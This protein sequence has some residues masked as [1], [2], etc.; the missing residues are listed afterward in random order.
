MP[1]WL[2]KIQT[3]SRS[4]LELSPKTAIWPWF[5]RQQK[6]GKVARD[7]EGGRA[8]WKR[9]CRLADAGSRKGIS[10]KE[11]TKR[12]V[13]TALFPRSPFTRENPSAVPI[14]V[15]AL[16]SVFCVPFPVFL[17]P[18]PPPHPFSVFRE[19]KIAHGIYRCPIC[20]N[21]ARC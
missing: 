4:S 8:G 6:Q 1:H 17:A 20:T 14:F 16:L 9:R 15:L 18:I 19:L 11:S 13:L 2:I 5:L 3:K 10:S 7:E 12:V 21:A